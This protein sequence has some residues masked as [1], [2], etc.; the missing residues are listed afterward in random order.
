MTVAS[1]Q[2]LR[3]DPVRVLVVEDSPPDQHLIRLRLEKGDGGTEFHVTLCETMREATELLSRQA[4]D[5]VLLDLGLPDCRGLECVRRVRTA[6]PHT[7][8]VVLTGNDNEQ[9][10][11][12][13]VRMGAQDF[14]TKGNLTSPVLRKALAYALERGAANARFRTMD[15]RQSLGVLAGGVAHE[16]NNTLNVILGHTRLALEMLEAQPRAQENLRRAILGAEHAASLAEQMLA[17]S[18]K[19]SFV[20]EDLDLD[21]VIDENLQLIR[22]ATGSHVQ[23]ERTRSTRSPRVHGDRRQVE[24]LIMCLVLNAAQAIEA[25][26]GRIGIRTTTLDVDEGTNGVVST[27]PEPVAHGRY[28]SLEIEDSGTGIPDDI[29]ARMFDP[30]FTTKGDSRGLGL[31]A[32]LG[33]VQGHGGHITVT[34]RAGVGSNFRVLLPLRER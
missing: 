1:P 20:L 33:I 26:E 4:A 32:A 8:I 13:A 7:P 9:I 24:Q 19:G 2:A 18:G 27:D 5:T 3:G 21:R 23:I 10:G 11:I 34:S 30:F 25:E 12:D 15:R 29:R 31:C 14:L 28:A 16:L 6:A 22:A 17:Y